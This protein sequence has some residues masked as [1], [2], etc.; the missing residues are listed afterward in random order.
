MSTS[1]RTVLKGAGATAAAVGFV[2]LG[3]MSPAQAA[4]HGV[5][6]APDV[7]AGIKVQV[8]A[9]KNWSEAIQVDAVWTAMPT[10]AQQVLDLAN[11]AFRNGWK[12]RAKGHSHTWCPITLSG[13][14]TKA[15]KLLL[16]D[17]RHGL[18][19]LAITT[20]KDAHVVVGTGVDQERLLNELSKQGLGIVQHPAPGDITV[21]GVLAIGGH[22]TAVPAQGEKRQRGQSFGSVSNLVMAMEA[23]VFD[24]AKGEYVLRRFKRNDPGIAPLLVNLGRTFITEV[25]LRVGQEQKMRCESFMDV[26]LSELLAAPGTKGR[27]VTSYL[28]KSGRMEIICFP[29]TKRPWLKV[30]TPTPTKPAFSRRVSKPFNYGFSD[31]LPKGVVNMVKSITQGAETMTPTLGQVQWA[32]V[33]SGLS[34]TDTHDLWGSAKDLLMYVRP[35]TLRV[36][37][38]GYAILCERKNIQRVLNDFYRKYQS[39]NAQFAKNQQYPM[40]GPLEIRVVGLDDPADVGIDGAVEALLSPTRPA[41]DHPEW[42]C[43]VYFDVLTL[44]GT[45]NANAYFAD[46]ERWMYAN[47]KGDYART[48]VEWSKGWAYT[49]A[50]PWQNHNMLTSLV[51][52]SLSEGHRPGTKYADA[53]AKLQ[54]YDPYR[55]F[56]APMHD[57]IMPGVTRPAPGGTKEKPAAATVPKQVTPKKPVVAAPSPLL[58]QPEKKFVWWNIF[59]WF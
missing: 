10:N 32:A 26:P 6:N 12:L 13:S 57:A 39:L 43:A 59:T 9:Y 46:L 34:M 16:V 22:G 42:D 4:E 28:D 20:G 47:Y 1:R 35:E 45:Q 8:Q 30:W 7:P 48:R 29:N 11:W 24:E 51:P 40:N 14:E 56:T 54:E 52:N 49:E 5:T 41:A 21:G 15:S 25:T 27:T 23:V 44:P 18:N 38:N 37:A 50:G 55:I 2:H 58:P 17:T 33:A 36:T 3:P 53:V 31:Q 19:K